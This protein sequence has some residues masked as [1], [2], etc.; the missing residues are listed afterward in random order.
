MP[1][2]NYTVGFLV[3][4][5][6]DPS[7]ILQRSTTHTMIPVMDYETLCDGAPDCPY[8]GERKNVIFLPSAN[9]LASS[10]DDDYDDIRVFFGGGDGNVGT[11]VLRVAHA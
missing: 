1:D 7:V 3:L 4:S 2:G 5:A 6:A 11:A 10:A 9:L 8:V